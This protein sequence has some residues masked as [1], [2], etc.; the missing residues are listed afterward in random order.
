LSHKEIHCRLVL[1]RDVPL[2][3]NETEVG[4]YLEDHKGGKKDLVLA[5]FPTLGSYGNHNFF[6]NFCRELFMFASTLFNS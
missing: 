3:R 4:I 6:S 2:L 1:L 5:Y